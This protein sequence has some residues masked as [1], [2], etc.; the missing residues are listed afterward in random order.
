MG[1][2][3]TSSIAQLE[4]ADARFRAM[5]NYITDFIADARSI[6]SVIKCDVYA[7]HVWKI[8]STHRT[9]SCCKVLIAMKNIT[10]QIAL[11]NSKTLA[12]F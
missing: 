1:D 2:H 8:T 5:L 3:V 12:T 10:T 11:I 6:P 7:F 9:C 4:L